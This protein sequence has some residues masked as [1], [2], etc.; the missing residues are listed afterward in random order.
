MQDVWPSSPA[1]DVDG[2]PSDPLADPQRISASRRLLTDLGPVDSLDRVA[3]LAARAV[4]APWAQIGLLTDA[5]V[6]IAGHGLPAGIV[7][8]ATPWESSLSVL[9]ARSGRT[10]AVPSTTRDPRTAGRDSVRNGPVAAY[11]GTPL[12][13]S[14]GYVVGVLGVTSGVPHGWSPQDVEV[15]EE[16]GASVVTELEL[17]AANAALG[18]SLT[19]LD[20]ALR[21]GD[22]GAWDVDLLTGGVTADDRCRMLLGLPAEGDLDRAAV[23][24]TVHP[25]DRPGVRQ[26]LAAAVAGGGDY[27][28]EARSLCP[29][30]RVRWVA[31]RGRVVMDPDQ[32]PVRVVGTVS[33]VTDARELAAARMAGL[34]RTAHI[35][36]VAGSL[37]GVVTVAELSD[38]A[39]RGARVLGATSGAVAGR[40]PDG[41]LRLHLSSQLHDRVVRHGVELA[42]DGLVLE[43]DD[44][45]PAQYTARTGETVLLP[46]AEAAVARFPGLVQAVELAGVQALASLPLRVEGRTVGSLTLTWAEERSLHADDVALLEVLAAQL[47]LT[48]SRL[49]ADAAR[50][51]AVQE[52]TAT[53]ERLRLL[54]DVGRV[55]SGTLDIAEQLNELTRLVVP[56]LGDWSWV[57]LPDASGRLREVASAHRDPGWAAEL[58]ALLPRLVSAASGH[59]GTRTV[60]TTGRPFV[61]SQITGEDLARAVPDP[62]ARAAF[63][64]FRPSSSV[65]VPL[66]ARGQV[67]GALALFAGPGRPPHTAEEVEAAAEI[68]RRA[69]IALHHARLFD[70]QRQLTEALQRS[71][72]TAPPEVDG[73]SI[74]VR[75]VPAASG[76][77]IG[78]DWYDA[79]VQPGGATSLAIG[80]VAGHDNRAAAAMGQVRSLLRGIAYCSDSSPARVLTGLDAAMHGLALPVLVTA[81]VA[82]LEQV[83]QDRVQGITRLR[84]SNAGHPA[85]V[86][87]TAD[88]TARLL[89]LP[90][91]TLLLGVDP[92]VPRRDDV[93]ALRAGDTVLLYT[94][95]L[96]ERRDRDLD[97]GTAELLRVLAGMSEVPLAQLCDRVLER[98]FLP[99]AEDDVALL[100]V[101]ITG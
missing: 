24:A 29:G 18:R 44:R 66:L 54:A 62:V 51:A 100:A 12:T 9:P 30:G 35:A 85:P 73:A 93:V 40:D 48:W 55:L 19:R 84:W 82:R 17:A 78:G 38:V 79:F 67:L 43:L 25:D 89:D 90:P 15:V 26:A 14:D 36:E 23:L 96:I 49:Q 16:L 76:A 94:D 11:L 7:G 80:D 68:G 75:Y 92:S 42:R 37:A 57:V 71:M 5:H 69:G 10:V 4:G 81:L 65:T 97:A 77:E 50:E 91:V 59:T 74:E 13:S 8:S 56:A 47:A 101:R 20:M 72:L 53:A 22:V 70:Q 95:G 52:T 39:L 87:L 83:E 88:G 27:R 32:G 45:M 3:R 31:S 2:A 98:M 64:R 33:D 28:T 21:A 58:R 1:G 99:D 63:D 41:R 46:T 60:L 6:V 86:L 34:Q 61:R